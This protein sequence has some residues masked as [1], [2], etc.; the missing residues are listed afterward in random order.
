MKRLAILVISLNLFFLCACGE[1]LSDIGTT[2]IQSDL[3]NG[4]IESDLKNSID[5]TEEDGLKYILVTDYEEKKYISI[6]FHEPINKDQFTEYFDRA[7]SSVLSVLDSEK[8]YKVALSFDHDNYNVL[9]CDTNLS[10]DFNLDIN[11]YEAAGDKLSNFGI[12]IYSALEEY[13]TYKQGFTKSNIT[14]CY[15]KTNS[16]GA[17][18]IFTTSI[19]K[20]GMLCD[21]RGGEN[22]STIYDSWDDVAKDFPALTI[23]LDF[24]ADA[25][26]TEPS[27]S[28][29]NATLGEL[30]A[31]ESA[32]SYLSFKT[33][34]YDGLVKQLEYE[35][36]SHAEATYAADYCGADWKEQAVKCAASYL[37]FTSFS[38][39]QL[40]TQLEY[41]GFT[42][43][44]AIYGATQNGY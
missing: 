29:S 4:N 44:Q 26:I 12:D 21:Y 20:I 10:T 25:S 6:A 27:T 32:K 41:E 31:L 39:E 14:V 22:K 28:S 7:R 42:H 1:S 8:I 2:N 38:R 16:D 18:L 9:R 43:D 13:S 37:S 33:F 40:I 5:L 30:N 35:K 15:E 11:Y 3:E 19:G 23:Y 24:G 34:S 17:D 36:Y